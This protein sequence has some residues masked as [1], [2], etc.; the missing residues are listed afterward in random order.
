M[1][2]TNT[3]TNPLDIL[4]GAILL[5]HRGK[6]LYDSVVE[7]SKSEG[8]KELFSMLSQE[9]SKHIR[10]LEKQ[11][12]RIAK[13]ESFDIAEMEKDHAS[14]HEAVIT[15]DIVESVSGAGYE[16]AVIA[17]ALEFEKKAVAF[18]SDRASS[19]ESE[20]EKKLY[21]WLTEWEK[22]HMLMMARLD[23]ELKE[24]IWFDNQFWPLD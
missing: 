9:E 17:A 12:A 4:K 14:T 24:K 22:N 8:V 23:N 13:G 2:E 19:T 5:E 15:R 20:Q 18:Y 11:F 10:I 7:T 3:N 16:A 6:A 21:Q 1:T